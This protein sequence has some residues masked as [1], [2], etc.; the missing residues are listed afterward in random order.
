[1]TVTFVFEVGRSVNQYCL[2]GG[3]IGGIYHNVK[4][5]WFVTDNFGNSPSACLS[6][7]LF[8]VQSLTP[9]VKLAA[10]TLWSP[11]QRG[12]GCVLLEAGLVGR[13][14]TRLPTRGGCAGEA[15]ERGWFF[16]GSRF[17]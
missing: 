1:M 4:C 13:V 7:R 6:R 2:F 10:W 11:F 9:P 5:M 14:P 8:N 15:G 16:K 3:K 17:L 12:S